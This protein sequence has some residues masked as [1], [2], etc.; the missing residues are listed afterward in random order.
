M[1]VLSARLVFSSA[2]LMVPKKPPPLVFFAELEGSGDSDSDA[3][4]F[5][6]LFQNAIVVFRLEAVEIF[7]GISL[8][9][10]GSQSLR[11]AV[12][13]SL[14]SGCV[15]VTCSRRQFSSHASS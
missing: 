7:V 1:S 4:V 2:V 12:D 9:F 10:V 14:H 5:F 11:K 6:F 3:V 8:A 15:I 13:L